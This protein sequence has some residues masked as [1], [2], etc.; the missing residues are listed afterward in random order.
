[1]REFN[2]QA[3]AAQEAE[4]EAI[5]SISWYMVRAAC[6]IVRCVYLDDYAAARHCVETLE[7]EVV[8][9]REHYNKFADIDP[10]IDP[11]APVHSR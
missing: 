8:R 5:N 7:E 6:H 10:T 1:M 4:R 3:L 9:L 2:Q 11:N